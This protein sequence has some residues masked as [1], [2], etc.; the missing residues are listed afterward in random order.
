MKT[1]TGKA[2][3]IG[4][5]IIS[6]LYF[7]YNFFLRDT[8]LN[9]S[10]RIINLDL[11]KEN[12]L[13]LEKF[14]EQTNTNHLEIELSGQIQKHLTYYISTDLNSNKTCIKVKK[15]QLNHLMIIP[16]NRPNC[17]LYLPK[18]G[19]SKIHLTYRFTNH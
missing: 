15:G 13:V 4:I 18:T 6:F 3:F 11:S 2:V 5:A 19:P 12:F 8:I 14:K 10:D 9:N 1:K 16:W 17:F 7:G